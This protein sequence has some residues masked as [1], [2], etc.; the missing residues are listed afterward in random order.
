MKITLSKSQWEKVGNE[1][2]WMKKASW[3]DSESGV[4]EFDDYKV[5]EKMLEMGGSFVKA[6]ARAY[7]LA[8][9]DNKQ[10]IKQAF[11]DYWQRYS[12]LAKM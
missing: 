8:D 2:G 12:D 10:R 9:S 5:V 4:V 11:Q 7:Q 1:A 3:E 6:L